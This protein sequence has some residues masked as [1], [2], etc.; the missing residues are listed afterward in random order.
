MPCWGGK[1]VLLED[2]EELHYY[3]KR[4][5]TF[6]SFYLCM[7]VFNQRQSIHFDIL[8][9]LI[10]WLNLSSLIWRVWFGSW[11]ENS[12]SSVDSQKAFCGGL[13]GTAMQTGLRWC[14][15]SSSSPVLTSQIKENRIRMAGVALTRP[16][17]V[18]AVQY[19]PAN[20]CPPDSNLRCWPLP[21]EHTGQ[22]L[23]LRRKSILIG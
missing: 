12:R 19:L 8:N 6:R 5:Q 7:K 20:Q 1:I 15:R 11:G 16:K 3:S 18:G 22:V 13:P 14:Y 10:A 9:S 23:Q 4:F 2:H 17:D 21:W